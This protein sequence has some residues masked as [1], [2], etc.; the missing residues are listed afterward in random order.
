MKIILEIDLKHGFQKWKIQIWWHR[1]HGKQYIERNNVKVVE[2]KR[3]YVTAN[4]LYFLAMV[5]L[6]YLLYIQWFQFENNVS[7]KKVILQEDKNKL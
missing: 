4:F 2:E 6:F 3:K 1:D 7:G 5:C